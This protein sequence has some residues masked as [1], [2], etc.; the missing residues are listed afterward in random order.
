MIETKF[1]RINACVS[2]YIRVSKVVADHGSEFSGEQARPKNYENGHKNNFGLSVV[3]ELKVE[4]STI[5]TFKVLFSMSKIH[6]ILLTFF[7]R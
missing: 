2:Q 3:L 4:N 6:Q 7:L 5:L 1:E